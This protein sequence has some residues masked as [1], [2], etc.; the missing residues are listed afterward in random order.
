MSNELVKEE[1]KTAVED[2]KFTIFSELDENGDGII[3]VE[4]FM[5]MGLKMPGAKINREDF[6]QNLFV[7]KYP[8]EIV[9]IVITQSPMKANIPLEDIN[10]IA[11]EVIKSEGVCVS[12]VLDMIS[13]P[14]DT[15]TLSTLK[16]NTA[17]YYGYLLRATQK[18]MYLYGFPQM[19]LEEKGGTIDEK[20]LN[21]LKM[22]FG[23]AVGVAIADKG[24]KYLAEVVSKKEINIDNAKPKSFAK[25]VQNVS[26]SLFGQKNANKALEGI[27]KKILPL[28]SSVI[29]GGITQVSFSLSCNKLK[30]VLQDTMLS[31]PNYKKSN[32]NEEIIEEVEVVEE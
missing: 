16:E 7:R 2:N 4:D 13:K 22:G 11:D 3:N 21:I 8:Q 12:G 19:D 14:A 5:L 17:Q 1:V 27:V 26:Y 24:I 31:N 32:K 20:F 15:T 23:V 25:F 9:D 6:L 10:K 28:I 18:L 29:K 30:R